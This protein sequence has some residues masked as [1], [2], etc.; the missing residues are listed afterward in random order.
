MPVLYRLWDCL[1]FLSGG[2]GFGVPAWEAMASELPVIYTNYSSH[3]EFLRKAN[4]G[5][6]VG[7]IL[8]PEPGSC[9]LRLVPD[10]GQALDAVRRLYGDAKLR[11][12]LGCRGRLLTENYSKE[13]VAEKWHRLF[14][15][16]LAEA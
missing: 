8:Q 12:S 13:L 9:I 15:D 2:E 3:A 11:S 6:P 14:Q 16:C 5:I 10:V 4:A 7:G 1:L